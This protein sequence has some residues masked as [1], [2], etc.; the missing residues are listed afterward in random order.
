M[1]NTCETKASCKEKLIQGIKGSYPK[2]IGL[3][4]GGIGGFEYY[5]QVGCA[6]GSCP[7]TSNPWLSLLW[8]MFT[9]YLIGSLFTNKK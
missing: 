5:S 1:N 3:L 4:I 2:I 6:S 7:I 8:G 9:G